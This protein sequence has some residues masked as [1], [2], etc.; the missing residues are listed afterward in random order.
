MKKLSLWLLASIF[1][2]CACNDDNT[3]IKVEKVA[4]FENLIT[5]PETDLI[6]TEGEVVDAY[7]SKTTFK[8]NQ[9]LIEFDHYFSEWGFGGGMLCTNKTDLTTP[10]YINNSAITSG[11]KN[12]SVYLTANGS[13]FSPA[14]LRNLQ[15]DTYEFKGAWI[16]NSVYAYLAIKDGNDGYMNQTKFNDGDWF[17]IE[18]VGYT[19]SGTE[20]GRAE[21]YLADYRDG[22]TE[23][24]N[25][26][27]W[28][29]WTVI[30]RAA[31]IDFILTSSD[32]GEF[33]I[34]TPAYFC[35]DGV[36]LIEK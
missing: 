2:L 17:K 13:T 19:T 27:K 31:Y 28:F 22:K 9:N 1:V 35:L 33:G 3:T 32:T 4:S 16:T 10:G 7:S 23:I 25:T 29:D 14:I 21:M 11:G 24:I 26:W 18:A 8:D 34:N 20:I 30:A 5:Q 36:T 6:A 12:G 15:A